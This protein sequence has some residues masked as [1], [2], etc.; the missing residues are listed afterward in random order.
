MKNSQD[1]LKRRTEDDR[2]ESG[3]EDRSIG[4]GRDREKHTWR[5][6]GIMSPNLMKLL[7]NK[8]KILHIK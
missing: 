7:A 8:F 3:R 4:E 6:S 2:R 1:G 5:D